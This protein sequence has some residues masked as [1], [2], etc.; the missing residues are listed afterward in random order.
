MQIAAR[1]VVLAMVCGTGLAAA[2][3]AG[4]SDYR[5]RYAFQGGGD[6]AI[7]SS[8]PM[9]MNGR[10]YGTTSIGGAYGRGAVVGSVPGGG[11]TV[12][13]SFRGRSQG[14]GE[15]PSGGVIA[16]GGKLYGMTY[17]G[18]A[19]QPYYPAGCGTIYAVDPLAGTETV[20]HRFK[21]SGDGSFPA[22]GLLNVGGTLF[23]TT[24]FGGEFGNGAVIAVNPAT[25]AEAV[26]YSFAGGSGGASPSSS[27]IAIGNTL[28][29]TTGSGGAY[30]LGTVFALNLATGAGTVLH[31]FQGGSDGA[32]PSGALLNLGGTLYG[33]ATGGG[34]SGA[35]TVFTVNP[36]TGAE[37]VLHAF[38][39]GPGDGSYPQGGLIAAAGTLYGT[40]WI[41]GAADAGTVYALDPVSG[42]VTLL[43]SFQGKA[44]DGADSQSALV[45]VGGRLYGTTAYGGPA[46]AGTVFSLKP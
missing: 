8:A 20:L 13:Y 44:G 36:A 19:P 30:G 31:A 15:Q 21:C 14:D 12:V 16:V 45:Y 28:Y 33:T 3:P 43:H 18:G 38:Q 46:N 27:L 24:T 7:P 34:P 11:E 37:A 6:G 2:C 23:G 41:G 26:V 35:G 42:A 10:F 39:G 40:T 17:Q 4:A 25:G 1:L 22:A 32:N 5:V 9:F 29:G